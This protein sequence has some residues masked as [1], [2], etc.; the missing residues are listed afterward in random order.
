MPCGQL[1]VP[2]VDLSCFMCRENLWFVRAINY[3]VKYHIIQSIIFPYTQQIESS[4]IQ[5]ISGVFGVAYT[6]NLCF[7]KCVVL[8]CSLWAVQTMNFLYMKH[9]QLY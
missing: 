1:Y 5:L 7:G 2:T 9:N 6:G 4:N 8:H 3:N